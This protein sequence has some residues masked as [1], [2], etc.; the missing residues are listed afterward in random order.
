MF[1]AV[2]LPLLI[3]TAL[4]SAACAD[5]PR[6]V[7]I[8]IQNRT[9][10]F[11]ASPSIEVFGSEPQP[12]AVTGPG[13]YQYKFPVSES[14]WFN[15]VDIK[16]VWANAYTNNDST[17]SDFEQR[18]LLRIRR[19]FPS[20]F[21][22]PI[23][24]SND[25]SQKEMSRLEQ[26]KDANQQFEVFFRGWQI[27]NYYR[28]TFGPQHAFTKRAAKIFFYGAV[29]LAETPAY[30]VKMSDEAEQFMTDAFG[31]SS[32][33]S[34]RANVARAVYWSDLKQIDVYVGKG[35]CAT[36]KMILAAFETLKSE[37]PNS[38]SAQYGND[39]D[40]LGEKAILINSKCQATLGPKP[41]G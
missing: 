5:D 20:N 33:F 32:S 29:Q 17:R 11:V 40:V 6:T 27:S 34:D 31:G 22:F 23:Y 10:S 4:S 30:F 39:P 26:E 7:T 19:E 25:R 21:S 16:I 35:D 12:F 28:D 18:V 13:T 37:D 38:F 15:I 36:A 2:I 3:C 24:F 8:T 14:D 41:S 9:P 1:R